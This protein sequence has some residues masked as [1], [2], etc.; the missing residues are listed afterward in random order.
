M[1]RA[2]VTYTLLSY[3]VPHDLVIIAHALLLMVDCFF[4][5]N[6]I[7]LLYACEHIIE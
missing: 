1:M 4:W 3:Q 2:I 6:N 7:S 5:I